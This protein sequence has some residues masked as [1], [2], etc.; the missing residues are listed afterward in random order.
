MMFNPNTKVG[1]I[2]FANADVELEQVSALIMDN[3]EKKTP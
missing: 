3:A 1:L 2:I